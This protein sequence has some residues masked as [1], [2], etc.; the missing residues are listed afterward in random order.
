MMMLLQSVVSVS[1][2]VLVVARAV[3]ILR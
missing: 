3:N 1:T 2:L